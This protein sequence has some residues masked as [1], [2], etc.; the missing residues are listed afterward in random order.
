MH[1]LTVLDLKPHV[2]VSCIIII[3]AVIYFYFSRIWTFLFGGRVARF[4]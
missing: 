4:L 3:A 2:Y 1:W